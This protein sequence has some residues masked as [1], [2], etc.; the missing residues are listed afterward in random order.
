[1]SKDNL[2]DV[3]FSQLESE[4]ITEI[5]FHALADKWT[6]ETAHLSSIPQMIMHPSYQAVVEMAERDKEFMIPLILKDMKKKRRHWFWLL[7]Q[8]T[9]EN[10]INPKD[11]GKV[12]KMIKAWTDWGIEKGYISADK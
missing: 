3:E 1:M 7:T 4:R 10:P 8:L 6:E 5:C 12:N 11:A 9:G 2:T